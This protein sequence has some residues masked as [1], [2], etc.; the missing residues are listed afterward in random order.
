ME[1]LLSIFEKKI[2]KYHTVLANL[3]RFYETQKTKR[4][5]LNIIWGI[6]NITALMFVTNIMIAF[7]LELIWSSFVLLYASV[8]WVVSSLLIDAL[9]GDEIDG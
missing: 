3:K 1:I 5:L 9:I 6:I 7:H 4:I 2:I 8:Y